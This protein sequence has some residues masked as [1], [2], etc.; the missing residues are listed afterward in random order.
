MKCFFINIIMLVNTSKKDIVSLTSN[1]YDPLFSTYMGFNKYHLYILKCIN[2]ISFKR[3]PY[4]QLYIENSLII[5]FYFYLQNK[6]VFPYFWK[7]SLIVEV[8]K[9]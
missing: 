3:K 9:S 5:Q 7:V 4:N 8:L 6:S 2:F 1:F